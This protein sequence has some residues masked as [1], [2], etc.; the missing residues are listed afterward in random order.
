MQDENAIKWKDGERAFSVAVSMDELFLPH[1][2]APKPK[3]QK[4]LGDKLKDRVV[5]IHFNAVAN[6]ALIFGSSLDDAR[7]IKSEL[8][9][10]SIHCGKNISSGVLHGDAIIMDDVQTMKSFNQS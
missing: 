2:A 1:S 6:A 9:K 4:L 7:L 3:V 10:A 8:E 5:G